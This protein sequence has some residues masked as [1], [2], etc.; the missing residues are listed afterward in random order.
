MNN[1]T[2][3]I[4]IVIAD[5]H[6]VVR[7]GI[8]TLL[9]KEPGFYIAGE[10]KNGMETVDLVKRLKPGL[11]LLDLMMPDINGIQVTRKI[12][13]YS[14]K[15]CV[16]ILSMHSNEAYVLEALKNGA[17]GYVLKESTGSELVR[18]IH[19]VIA[20]RRFLSP[21]LSECAIEAYV[22]TAGKTMLDIY[23]TLTN[24]E[25]EV[26]Q[27]SAEGFNTIDIAE[28]LSI[29][30]RTA[31]VHRYNLMHKLGLHNQTGLVR[32]AIQRGIV[33]LKD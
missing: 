21:P 15:T 25:R 29:S 11:V 18:A 24:R 22:R 2:T 3:S 16:I 33:T 14:S 20:G 8:R 31:E 28:K 23:G 12:K 4:T 1:H 19:E 32:Y 17:S 9:E 5:D 30:L 26:L 6:D 27:L 13:K 10:A 7:L